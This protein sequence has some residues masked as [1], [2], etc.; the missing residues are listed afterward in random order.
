[1]RTRP[2]GPD[3]DADASRLREAY[4]A[5]VRA[6]HDRRNP[7]GQPSRYNS[8]VTFDGGYH[9]TSGR[10]YKPLWPKL[11]A[12]AREV[13][14][15]PVIL[16]RVLFAAWTADNAP[17]PHKLLDGDN[18]GRCRRL[19]ATRRAAVATALR[20]EEAVFRSALWAAAQSVTDAPAAVRYVL[21]DMGQPMSPLFRLCAARLRGCD[22]VAA[23]WHA[24]AVA[25]YD[26]EP[27]YYRE[28]WGHILP[29]GWPDGI[30]TGVP[31]TPKANPSNDTI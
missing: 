1:M 7:G 22:D 4:V 13:G 30:Q 21:N 28:S 29:P 17:T 14:F 31:A 20:T 27:G 6:L 8:N 24:A 3:D 9:A 11:A 15:D 19:A 2:A 25:Q 12:Q 26:A 10:T 16:V 18:V 5:A 23:R